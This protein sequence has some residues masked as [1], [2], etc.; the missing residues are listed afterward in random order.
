MSTILDKIVEQTRADLNR[1]R[2]KV[3]MSDFNSFRQFEAVR[4][5]FELALRQD[6]FHII[7]E[8][9]KASPSKGILRADFNAVDIAMKYE[10]NGAHCLSIL[11]DEPFFQGSLSYLSDIR[12]RVEL[13]LLRKDFII[14]PYQ[15]AEARAF[16]A[17]AILLIAAILSDTHLDELLHAAGE[18]GLKVLVECYDEDEVSRMNWDLVTLFGVNNRDLRTFETDVHR[19]IRLLQMAPEGVL[20][21]SES[22]LS[23]SADL[24]LLVQGD[25]HAALIGESFMRESDPGI[26][27][28]QML[29]G[30][31]KAMEEAS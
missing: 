4:K 19:G 17:D 14:D 8:V 9:K 16:G 12:D 29:D 10:D 23:S 20:R 28:R 25:I 27:M 6:S 26:A 21:V 3:A 7:A 30:L 22:G 2:G 15:I 11:T 5:D 13:P 18:Y 1:R 31:N 24:H